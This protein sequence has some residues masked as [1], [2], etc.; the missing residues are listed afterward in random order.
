MKLYIK[1]FIYALLGV[2]VAS[3]DL[4]KEVDLELPDYEPQ[5]VVEA[6]LTP[7][8]PYIVSLIQS[9]P[10]YDEIRIS[11]IK[12][13]EVTIRYQDKEVKLVR[14]EVAIPDTSVASSQL[15]SIV[16]DTIYTYIALEQ[17]P[18]IYYEDFKL[19]IT[20]PNG[21]IITSTTQIFPPVM[22]DTMEYK[23]NKDSLAFVLTK[24]QDDS[25]TANF[26][27]ITLHENDIRNRPDQDFSIDD[28][29]TNGELLTFG[30]AYEYEKGD[31]LIR[32]VYHITE[33]YH[34]FLETSDAAINANLSPFGQPAT[35]YTNVT[36][37]LGIFTGITSDRM[38]I[39]IE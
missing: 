11:Y 35:L 18:E 23:F 20:R 5:V 37:G 3:C 30:T 36:G 29:L 22:I 31:T 32:T 25:S 21:E 24:F 26:Y 12:D 16:G 4:Q 28:V 7:G 27:R 19:E 14:F 8:Q 39:V 2:I 33:D 38:T 1:I 9:V 34:R 13:A 6:Y 17:V 15:N 10:Y